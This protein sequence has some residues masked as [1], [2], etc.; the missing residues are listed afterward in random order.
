MDDVLNTGGLTATIVDVSTH[1]IALMFLPVMGF[2]VKKYG[3]K[4]SVYWGTITAVLGYG[5]IFFANN[6]WTVAASYILIVFTVNYI[7]T[8]I[9]PMGALIIDE[10]ERT[11]GVRKTGLFNGLFSLFI[12]AF[13]SLQTVIFINVIGAFGYYGLAEAQSDS[14]VFGI[15]LATGL[16]PLMAIIIGLIPMFFY[17]FDKKKEEEISAFSNFARRGGP[18]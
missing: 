15:R 1:V 9:S 16:I 17:P 10:N 12:V 13:S 2:I 3:T 4:T 5:G 7:K 8:A 14:A 18:N 11:T 6:I